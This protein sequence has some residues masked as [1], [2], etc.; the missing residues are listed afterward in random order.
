[1]A[2]HTPGMAHTLPLPG[3]F[4]LGIITLLNAVPVH[5]GAAHQAPECGEACS[6]MIGCR[7]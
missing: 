4:A 2:W 6:G 5:L 7:A 3:Q 1:M